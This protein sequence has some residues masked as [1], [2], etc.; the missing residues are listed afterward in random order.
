MF[1]RLFF[2]LIFT[3]LSCSNCYSQYEFKIEILDNE[4][5]NLVD[6]DVEIR[7]IGEG[8]EWT[9]GP[10]YVADGDYLLFSD[11][12]NNA[13]FKIDSEGTLTTYLKP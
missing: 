2:G 3:L 8:F 1:K 4:A 5:L 10:L 7:I 13:V 11:I 6:P 9:E 12:P